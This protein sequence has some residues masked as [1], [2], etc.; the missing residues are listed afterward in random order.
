MAS[1]EEL[2]SR[3]ERLERAV[4]EVRQ[5]AAAARVLAGAADRDVAEFREELRA[6]TRMLNTLRET[7]VEQGAT[8]AAQGD[9]LAELDRKVTDGFS[10]LNVGMARIVTLLKPEPE[11]Q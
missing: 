1:L 10:M 8:Q 4:V 2:E 5:D 6:H 7:Q 11:A 3:V 9:R